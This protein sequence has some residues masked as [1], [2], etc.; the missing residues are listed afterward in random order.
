MTRPQC[1]IPSVSRRLPIPG[2]PDRRSVRMRTYDYATAGI[3][4]V[5]IC[6]HGK[7][8]MLGRVQEDRA[9]LSRTGA[10]V[11]EHWRA[12]PEHNPGVEL[13]AFVV[14]PNHL[15]GL[16]ILPKAR[17]A[18]HAVPLRNKNILVPERTFGALQPRELPTLVRSFKAACT[19]RV[20]Q[21]RGAPGQPLWQ[22]GYH[23]HVV[24]GDDDLEQL[25]R[26]IAENPLRWA[27][28]REN[29]Q[30]GK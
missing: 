15:H 16:I 17:R 3:Y 23:E 14:M 12:I 2:L 18:Q 1:K 27:L 5:T 30:Y 29:P 9:V 20:N 13:D 10:V 6:T 22:R 26:Y 25:Q 19:R 7:K 24:R 8:C 21:L 4:F 11:E 28:D